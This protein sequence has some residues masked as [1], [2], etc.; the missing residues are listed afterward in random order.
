MNVPTTLVV[1]PTMRLTALLTALLMTACASEG[2]D[3][4]EDV[5]PCEEAAQCVVEECPQLELVVDCAE[6]PSSVTGDCAIN[7]TGLYQCGEAECGA[8]ASAVGEALAS[9]TD[10]YTGAVCE[11]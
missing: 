3:A 4:A 5:S 6:D 11:G 2:A 7:E 9:L 10:A 8:D 1:S